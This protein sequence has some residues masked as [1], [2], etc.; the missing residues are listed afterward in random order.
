MDL[1]RWKEL[2]LE[3]LAPPHYCL[4]EMRS[5][6]QNGEP[7]RSGMKRF[8]QNSQS[9]FV[10]VVRQFLFDYD[11]GIDWRI[12]L[13]KIKSPYRRSLLELAAAA[14]SGQSIQSPLEELRVELELAC[15]AEIKTRIDM[16][17]LQMLFPLLLLLFPSYLIL[18]FGPLVSVFIREMSQ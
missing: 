1:A 13:A 15:N 17:P 12:N 14:F 11:H 5:A 2:E 7:V 3:G 8:V 4:I 6:L 9:D 18:L 10:P 16:L